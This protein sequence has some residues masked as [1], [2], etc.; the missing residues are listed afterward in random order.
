[1]TMANHDDELAALRAQRMKDI[2]DQ[3]Q[4]QAVHQLEAEEKAQL[5]A[6]QAA[7]VDAVL[8]RHLSPDARARLARIAMVEPKR[9]NAI[10]ADLAAM[11]DQEMINTPL[12]DASLKQI[13][14]QL[15]KSRSNASV[16]RI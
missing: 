12:S 11:L 10:K 6:S 5:E 14:A 16:R 9:A 15:S 2:Q 1:M 8:R 4:Q 3:I 13:L 7:N